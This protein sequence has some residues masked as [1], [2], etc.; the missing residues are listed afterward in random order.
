VSVQDPGE[1]GDSSPSGGAVSLAPWRQQGIGI[2]RIVFGVVWAI[3]A[4]FKWQPDFINKFTAYLSGAQDGQPRWVSGWIGFWVKVVNVDPHVFAHLVAVGETAVAI[5][6]LLGLFSN[7][8]NVG[9]VLLSTVIWSTAEGFGGPY[10]PGSTDIGAAIIYALV[11]A[12][13]FLSS[14]GLSLGLDRR[15]SRHL[16]RWQFLASGSGGSAPRTPGRRIERPQ[17][18]G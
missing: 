2:L 17:L 4:W 10:Q 9:G 18:T 13:L 12:G 5:G 15:L 14:A 11:F 1:R 7:L 6:L 3:D 8:T 16:G